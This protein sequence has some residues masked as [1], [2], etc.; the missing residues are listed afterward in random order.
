MEQDQKE[1]LNSALKS[2]KNSSQKMKNSINQN[3]MKQCLKNA[4]ELLSE[5]KTSLLS[6]KN[7]YQLYSAIFDEIIYLQNY[8]RDESK[9]GRRIKEL[10]ETVQHSISAIPRVY[11]LII[12]GTIFIESEQCEKKE[13]V[14]YDIIQMSK[15]VQ[16]PIRGLFTRYFLLKMLKD[17]LNCI[18]YLIDNFKDMNKLWIRINKM[19][20]VSVE[21]IVNIRNDM[22]VLV[23]ENINR[24]ACLNN[25]NSDIYRDKILIPIFQ[26]ISL[27]ND[28][29]CQQ[30][31][32]ECL[33]HAF[34]DEFNIKSM[35]FILNSLPNMNPKIDI[36]NIIIS[37]LD[38][39]TKFDNPQKKIDIQSNDILRKLDESIKI[40]INEYN[41]NY[42]KNKDIL[43][44]IQLQNS[45]LKFILNFITFDNPE[46]KYKSI[47][48]ITSNLYDILNKEIGNKKL[49]NEGMRLINIFLNELLES[50]IS[51]FKIKNFPDLMF[52]LEGEYKTSLTLRIINS[53]VNDFNRGNIDSYDKMESLIEFITPMIKNDNYLDYN[54]ILFDDE[55]N[56]ISKLVYI[57]SSHNPQEQFEM[58]CL[59]KNTLIDFSKCENLEISNKKLV[60]YYSNLVNILLL[61]IYGV[62]EAYGNKK[63]IN[64][65]KISKKNKIHINFSNNYNIEDFDL[66]KEDS[67]L[68]FYQ[69][70]YKTINEILNE[71][72][73]LSPHISFKL[74]LECVNNSNQLKLSNKNKYEELCYSFLS[75]ALELIINGKI[76]EEK[77]FEFLTNLYGTILNNKTLSE[78]NY[79]NLANNL[80]KISISL[81]K[82]KEQC[83]SMINCSKL[84]Y[85]VI[86]KK[87]D[88][89][90]ECLLKAK[91]FAEYAMT[92]PNNAILFIYILN[93]YMRY[94]LLIPNFNNDVDSKYI[95]E[96]IELIKNYIVTIKSENKNREIGDY[97]ENYFI[98]TILTI[99]DRREKNNLG[100][101]GK[102]LLELNLGNI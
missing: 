74:Y 70:V 52:F 44:I 26:I 14:I 83:I 51:I 29:I 71:L 23:G 78:D 79:I 40:I 67:F 102:I 92:S 12:V 43:K 5:L 68:L 100:E 16:N 54:E 19:N 18:D 62:N 61:L 41:N 58:I 95:N 6:P 76:S 9:R 97:I 63:G 87:K 65:I 73:K 8:F 48:E 72:S 22:K 39:L 60:Y 77:K 2:V 32:I 47:N 75:S 86:L 80:E 10:Y 3:D 28:E 82:R 64:N 56:T 55:Q 45:Y 42:N 96:L 57:P 98:N 21:Q 99:K 35:D 88:K 38:K 4:N 17:Y 27:S 34:P 36:N 81:L 30:Y 46:I 49:S 20:N 93:E 101:C 15:G 37:I 59:L 33:I 69:N 84:Y 1:F 90:T 85:N 24:L 94:D 91:K 11:L 25:L 31:I 66:E 7:Y 89:L 13:E 53:F 50:P